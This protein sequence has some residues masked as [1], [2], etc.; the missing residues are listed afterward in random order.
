M[1]ESEAILLNL[2]DSERSCGEV[3]AEPV[4]VSWKAN[5]VVLDGLECVLTK[6]EDFGRSEM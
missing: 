2:L 1:R 4:P 5:R 6:G 3:A